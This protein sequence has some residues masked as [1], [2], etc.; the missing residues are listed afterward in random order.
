MTR[1]T[2]GSLINPPLNSGKQQATLSK[3]HFEIT[4][5]LKADDHGT[6]S[7]FEQVF[8]LSTGVLQCLFKRAAMRAKTHGNNEDTL[9]V[10]AVFPLQILVNEYPYF[11]C[12]VENNSCFEIVEGR[13]CDAPDFF[14]FSK[15]DAQESN[16][17]KKG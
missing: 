1:F 12:F 7:Q 3:V 5:L 2:Y 17:G 9:Y 14:L 11:A 13:F 10:L 16:N 15:E 8:V 4:D 6:K